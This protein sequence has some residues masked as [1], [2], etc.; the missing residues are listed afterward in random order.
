MTLITP[1]GSVKPGAR[2][3]LGKPAPAEFPA[4]LNPKKKVWESAAPHL[5]VIESGGAFIAAYKNEPLQVEGG[6]KLVSS[7]TGSIG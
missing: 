7:S 6:I 3:T 4:V 1:S 5:A 2:V